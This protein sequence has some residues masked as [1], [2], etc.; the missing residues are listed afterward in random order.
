MEVDNLKP[1]SGSE[2][3]KISHVVSFEHLQIK[4][5]TQHAWLGHRAFW[6]PG[7]WRFLA[8][9][10]WRRVSREGADCGGN[11]GAAW[12]SVCAPQRLFRRVAAGCPTQFINA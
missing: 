8:R 11:A 1:F 3:I 6:V 2:N 10:G 5:R 9:V 7:V 4:P 12:K